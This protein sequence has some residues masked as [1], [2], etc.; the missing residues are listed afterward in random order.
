MSASLKSRA[1]RRVTSGGVGPGAT[2]IPAMR[3]TSA[4]PCSASIAARNST[5]PIAIRQ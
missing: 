4:P 2:S 1:T 3:Y 5:N